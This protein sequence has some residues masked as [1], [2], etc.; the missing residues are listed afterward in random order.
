[1][2]SGKLELT[3]ANVQFFVHFTEFSAPTVSMSS[4][5]R[6]VITVK[7]ILSLVL[8]AQSFLSL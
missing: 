4:V 2:V 7:E 5:G 8:Y 6:S 3:Q 1:M